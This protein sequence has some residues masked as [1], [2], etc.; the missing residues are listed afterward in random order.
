M[1]KCRCCRRGGAT[2]HYRM[3]ASLDATG[4]R[5][6][7][8]NSRTC[9]LFINDAIAALNAIFAPLTA[10]NVICLCTVD[11]AF[12][13]WSVRSRAPGSAVAVRPVHWWCAH[14][15]LRPA[16]CS[17]CRGQE[18][19]KEGGGAAC[20][21]VRTGRC[22]APTLGGVRTR[23]YPQV[24][25]PAAS[26]PRVVPA[27][28]ADPCTRPPLAVHAWVAVAREGAEVVPAFVAD[29]CT[30]GLPFLSRAMLSRR[31]CLR[32]SPALARLWPFLSH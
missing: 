26:P 10:G 18:S 11:P 21:E 29:P 13:H 9:R 19:G 8:S 2:Q 12:G 30:P 20:G 14:R 4:V 31:W 27:F 6:R 24:S 3:F 32:S 5:G 25:R 15:V 22:G 16:L 17:T 1:P 28:V 7:W 23:R